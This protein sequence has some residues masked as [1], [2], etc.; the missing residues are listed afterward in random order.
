MLTLSVGCSMA[1]FAVDATKEMKTYE[2]LFDVPNK[3]KNDLYVN[4]NTWFV[5]TFNSAESVIEY[6]DKEAGKIMGKY[7][8]ETID[9]IHHYNIKQT[10][11]IDIKDGRVKVNIM[12]AYYQ[13]SGDN[14]NGRYYPSREFV[15][16]NSKKI[17]EQVVKPKWKTLIESL[18]ISLNKKTDW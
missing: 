12:D 11:A 4:A 2:E 13:G 15:A 5:N 6:Q 17:Y 7:I 14:L 10:I 9:G 18:K 1:M 3:S 8:F 16:L